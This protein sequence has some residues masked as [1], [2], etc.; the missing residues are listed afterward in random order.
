MQTWLIYSLLAVL[1]WGVWGF[2][3]K[4][5][6]NYIPGV[7]IRIF[8]TIGIVMT[9]ILLLFFIK[10]EFPSSN[11]GIFYAIVTG[12]IGSLGVL[13]F[14]FAIKSGKLAVV[15]PLTALYPAL[16]VLLSVLILKEQINL[17][18]GIGILFA[19]IAGILLSL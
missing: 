17:Y 15:V 1:T 5:A 10:F 9:T 2:F 18:Q 7:Y 3:G 6:S 19:I 13:F 14:Y 4:L 8:E 12:F 16:T 11:I